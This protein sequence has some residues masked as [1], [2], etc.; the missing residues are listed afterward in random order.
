[1]H[2]ESQHFLKFIVTNL[3]RFFTGEKLVLDVGSGDFNG[4]NRPL[5]DKSCIYYGNDVVEGKGVNMVYKTA[6]LPFQEPTFDTIVSS[7]CFQN[8][9]EYA[10]SFQKITQILRPGGL[11]AFTCASTGCPEFGTRRSLIDRSFA[12]REGLPKWRDYYKPITYEDLNTSILLPEVFSHYAAYYNTKSMD[13]MFVGIKHNPKRIQ[14]QSI[15]PEYKAPFVEKIMSLCPQDI[16]EEAAHLVND[17]PIALPIPPTPQPTPLF[18]TT[19]ERPTIQQLILQEQP[20]QTLKMI[21]AALS[22]KTIEEPPITEENAYNEDLEKPTVET[23]GQFSYIKNTMPK[24][25]DIPDYTLQPR[26]SNKEIG[27]IFTSVLEDTSIGGYEETIKPAVGEVIGPLESTVGEVIGSL[28]ATIGEVIGPLEATVGETI[29]TTVGETIE[30]IHTWEQ[31]VS[32]TI[33]S[34]SIAQTIHGTFMEAPE[35]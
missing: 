16:L 23:G 14:L 28:E 15:I 27:N 22:T 2:E 3:K 32:E 31:I 1:M 4:T 34:E 17:V 29:N 18:Q 26:F 9:P 21:T 10:K 20:Q 5:F 19:A 30:P 24:K 7:E 11:F 35:N 25:E 8:D 33:G 12:A 13:F 6:D